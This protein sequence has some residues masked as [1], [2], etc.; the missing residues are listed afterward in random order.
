MTQPPLAAH[1][2][3]FQGST[4]TTPVESV[5]LTAVLKRI[6]DG[7]YQQDVERLRRLLNEKG[8]GRYDSAKKHSMAFTP[9]GVFAHRA[10]AQLTTARLKHN[11]LTR[12][13]PQMTGTPYAMR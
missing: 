2:S 1:V 3:V 7:T 5:P 13:I 10:N 11:R 8:K 12:T 9:A 4:N 6:Q